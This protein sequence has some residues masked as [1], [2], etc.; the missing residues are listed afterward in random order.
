VSLY[1][2]FPGLGSLPFGVSDQDVSGLEFVRPPVHEV[3]GRIVVRKG[4]L[5]RSF[6]AFSTPQDFVG[7]TVNADGTFTTRLHS[8]RHQVELGGL[9]VGY[10]IESVRLGSTEL[11]TDGLVVG[12]ADV[13][14]LV[15]TV[16][17]PQS[18]PALKGRIAAPAGS[19]GSARVEITGPV[20]GTLEAPVAADG[21][22]EFAA[23]PKGLYRLR[24]PQ[25]PQIAPRNVVVDDRGADVQLA[26]Q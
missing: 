21:S 24:V 6:L 12:N 19:L 18:L 23:L 15:I 1:P 9:P 13:S 11:M 3:S 8:A 22:F 26:A 14:G 20:I 7:A 2:A 5:P 16:R 25:L 10:G 4:P 17:P